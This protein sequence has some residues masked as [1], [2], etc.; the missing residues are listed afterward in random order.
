MLTKANIEALEAATEK[1]L[2]LHYFGSSKG[3]AKHRMV[4]RMA[5]EGLFE[6]TPPYRITSKGL[7]LLETHRK[8]SSKG[9]A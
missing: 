5:Q 6:V 9:A 1:G 8:I 3:G 7:V 4:K 2:P